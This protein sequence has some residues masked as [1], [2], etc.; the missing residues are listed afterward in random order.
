MAV[1]YNFYI[2]N[3][4]GN[5]IAEEDWER[6]SA[7]AEERITRYEN[8]YQVTYFDTTDG[9]SMAI[10]A[11]AE[12]VQALDTVQGNG[13]V[14][15]VSVGSVSTSYANAGGSGTSLNRSALATLR[16]YADIYRG[17]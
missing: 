2:E 17:N 7:R 3:Y 14:S 13:A 8:I 4:H 16:T 6:L 15:S 10:C 5:L 9:R 1:D 12:T 11:L